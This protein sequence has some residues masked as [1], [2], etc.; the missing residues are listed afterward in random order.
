MREFRLKRKKRRTVFTREQIDRLETTFDAKRYLS[1][2][3]RAQLSM[4]LKMTETQVKVWFQNRRNKWKRD[5]AFGAHRAR[6]DRE[7]D[8]V[9]ILSEKED[10]YDVDVEDGFIDDEED[11]KAFS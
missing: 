2:N 11:A 3:D 8:A 5:Q 1:S 10:D 6:S 7:L 9:S 4:T